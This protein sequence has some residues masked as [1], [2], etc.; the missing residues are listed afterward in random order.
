[1]NLHKSYIKKYKRFNQ[2][3]WNIQWKIS[4]QETRNEDRRRCETLVKVN[5]HDFGEL[6]TLRDPIYMSS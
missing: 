3:A 4:E 6:L 5:E 2:T 1:M